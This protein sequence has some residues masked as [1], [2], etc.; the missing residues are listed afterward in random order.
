MSKIK[1]KV[2]ISTNLLQQIVC[3]LVVQVTNKRNDIQT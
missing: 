3:N 1:N 2:T